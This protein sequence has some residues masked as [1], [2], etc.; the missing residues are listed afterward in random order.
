[1]PNSPTA[2]AGKQI[3]NTARGEGSVRKAT[4]I[5]SDY[6]KAYGAVGANVQT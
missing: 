6:H 5:F 1:M 2:L 3:I 4:D